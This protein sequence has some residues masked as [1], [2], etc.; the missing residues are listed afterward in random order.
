MVMLV[1][2]IVKSTLPKLQ[3]KFKINYPPHLI[4]STSKRNSKFQHQLKL[5]FCKNLNDSTSFL[6]SW[7]NLWLIWNVHLSVRS[8]CHKL[9]TILQ[10]VS[11]KD[12]YL[13]N[14]LD[15]LLNLW[16]TWLTG[17]SISSEDRSNIRTGMKLKNLNA[18][19]FLDFTFLNLI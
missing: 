14:G 9:L 1:V 12:L 10:T 13:H 5:C 4:S 16:R 8:V 7:L 17:L 6:K 3:L 19:G 2:L 18:Y 15:L 11:S